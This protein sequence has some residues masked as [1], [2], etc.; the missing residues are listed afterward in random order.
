MVF[1]NKFLLHLK[2][3]EI[4]FSASHTQQHVFMFP[5]DLY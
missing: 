1:I 2:E 4:I 3:G 5:C